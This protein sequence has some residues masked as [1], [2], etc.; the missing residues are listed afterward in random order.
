MKFIKPDTFN[1]A[2]FTKECEKANIKINGF[3]DNGEGLLVIDTD[4][5]NEKAIQTV[6]NNHDGAD[7]EN[8]E[9]I[10]RRSAL[11]KLLALGLTEEEIAAL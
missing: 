9:I 3:F 4:V 8:P 1:G 7:I 10:A 2:T 5:K 11:T 6:L